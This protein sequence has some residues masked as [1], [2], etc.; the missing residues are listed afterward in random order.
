MTFWGPLRHLGPFSIC[1]K[2]SKWSLYFWDTIN[3]QPPWTGFNTN[4]AAKAAYGPQNVI[5]GYIWQYLTIGEHSCP[6]WV[7]H[8]LNRVDLTYGGTICTPLDP[9]KMVPRVS[10]GPQK[11]HFWP[12]LLYLGILRAAPNLVEWGI[13]EKIIQ[14]RVQ[15]HW[16]HGHRNPQS[17]R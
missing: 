4:R 11:G 13:P 10:G 5:F 1:P 3:V 6:I 2:G 15:T 17:K 16:P 12:Y 9:S 7:E 14:N 8:R